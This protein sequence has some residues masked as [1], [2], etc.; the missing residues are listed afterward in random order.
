MGKLIVTEFI[1]LDGIIDDPGGSEGHPHGGWSFRFPA[2]E[3]QQFKFEE[4]LAADVQLMGRVTYEGFAAAWP[5]MEESTGEFGKRMN[6]MP[7]V[8]VSTTLTDPAWNNTTVISADVPAAVAK[9]KEQYQG[10]VLVPA[11]ATLV[12]TLREHDLVDEYHLMVHP[13]VLGSGKR[14]FKEGA[15]GTDLQLTDCRK[16]GPDVLLLILQPASRKNAGVSP[17]QDVSPAS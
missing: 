5:G 14:L 9:L 7:K 1:T 11:S 3:G 6:S 12:D 16:A 8:V 2:P 13:V 4:L 15:A 17:A 10:D